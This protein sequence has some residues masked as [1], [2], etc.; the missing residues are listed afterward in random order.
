[1]TDKARQWPRAG[2]KSWKFSI[3]VKTLE[4]GLFYL[5]N[6]QEEDDYCHVEKK[7]KNGD[8]YE[9]AHWYAVHLK[10]YNASIFA[11]D[12]LYIWKYN[13]F[14]ARKIRGR[15]IMWQKQ[16]IFFRREKCFYLHCFGCHQ[17]QGPVLVLLSYP[18]RNSAN[19]TVH[20][21]QLKQTTK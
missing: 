18:G 19:R 17:K 5:F 20:I 7:P 14:I 16:L 12:K 11:M 1:M 4:A 8:W 2:L 15:D 6:G 3:K 9:V 21:K 13:H 10:K